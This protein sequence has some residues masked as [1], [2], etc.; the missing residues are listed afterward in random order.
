M[1]RA[2]QQSVVFK[3]SP[4]TLYEMFMDSKKHSAAT[5]GVARISRKVGGK[6]T[7]WNNMLRG[8]TL[9]LVPDRMIVQSWR[10]VMF[11][12]S[13]QDSILVITFTKIAAGTRLDLVHV[14]VPVQDHAG[15]SQGWPKY[16]WKPWRRYLKARAAQSS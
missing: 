2:I 1:T 16:Y 5:G 7:A 12:P 14:N 9:L 10:S 4:H 6:F 11:K 8:R 15:V 3:A 13:D